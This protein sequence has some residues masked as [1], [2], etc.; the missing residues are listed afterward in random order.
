LRR[1]AAPRFGAALD[2]ATAA[3]ASIAKWALLLVF[4]AL[5]AYAMLGEAE[6]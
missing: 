4:W 6:A 2:Y 1:T 3:T 5:F